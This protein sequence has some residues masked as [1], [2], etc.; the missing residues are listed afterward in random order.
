MRSRAKWR[1][2]ATPLLFLLPFVALF[3]A[4]WAGP[5]VSSFAY[6]FTA[7]RG[8]TPPEFIGLQNYLDLAG[9]ER[10]RQALGN[11]LWMTAAYATLANLLALLLALA[12]DAGWMRLRQFFRTA[13]FLPMTVSIVVSAVVF[14]L[15]YA[16]D[17]GLLAQGLA[18][19][20]IRG[21][22]WL[23]SPDYAPWAIV[24]MR[25]WRTT[26]YYAVILLA[27]LQAVPADARE[28]ARLDGAREWQVVRY[29]VLPA[30]RPVLLFCLTLSTVSGLEMFD[31]VM[32]LTG[33][34]PADA[35]LTA[36]LYVYQQGFQFLQLGHAAAASYVVTV[37]ILLIAAAQRLLLRERA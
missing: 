33:G 26:G 17:I 23:R 14:Q 25:T 37:L 2:H 35:T 4:F 30:L 12:L 22:A 28:S 6:S 20:G 36:V 1:R 11:T 18:L 21:P 19:V 10:F 27:G 15:I 16:G 34:G 5:I 7:W 3:G 32:V 31:E 9:S 29:V 8:I 24:L 13:F